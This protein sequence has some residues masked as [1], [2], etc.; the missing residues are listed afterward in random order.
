MWH[1]DFQLWTINEC[2]CYVSLLSKARKTRLPC[3][4]LLTMAPWSLYSPVR[5]HLNLPILEE[6]LA[7][8]C[9]HPK[10][11]HALAGP[12]DDYISF[13]ILGVGNWTKGLYSLCEQKINAAAAVDTKPDMDEIDLEDGLHEIGPS[14]AG[15]LQVNVDGPFGAPAQDHS[16]YSCLLLVVSKLLIL[17]NVSISIISWLALGSWSFKPQ[18]P[19]ELKFPALVVNW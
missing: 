13:H 14:L 6:S 5:E 3:E 1:Q 18:L 8:T 7:Y 12:G 10:D 16:S 4:S 2:H 9:C 15:S 19:D 17:L 11:R